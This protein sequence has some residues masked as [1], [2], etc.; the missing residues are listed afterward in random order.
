MKKP[1]R[2]P[3]CPSLSGRH[4]A[5]PR[6]GTQTCPGSQALDP[7]SVPFSHVCSQ[8]NPNAPLHFKPEPGEVYSN[9]KS[10]TARTMEPGHSSQPLLDP[11]E[12]QGGIKLPRFTTQVTLWKKLSAPL[13]PTLPLLLLRTG[14][15]P[16]PCL[17]LELKSTFWCV[18][19]RTFMPPR[20][21][22]QS[23]PPPNTHRRG[24]RKMCRDQSQDG[25]CSIASPERTPARAR[26]RDHTAARGYLCKV[27]N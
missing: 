16:G 10:Q 23:R 24:R 27:Q 19:A 21:E 8:K 1:W 25:L 5:A 7:G 18:C 13:P 9:A 14:A 26:L 11:S 15:C 6:R 12:Y 20:L 2:C 17:G 3:G 22:K 4:P